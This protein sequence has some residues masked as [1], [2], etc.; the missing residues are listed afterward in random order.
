MDTGRSEGAGMAWPSS[1]GIAEASAQKNERA[2]WR[3]YCAWRIP[4]NEGV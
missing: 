2:G 3:T 1:A 4:V